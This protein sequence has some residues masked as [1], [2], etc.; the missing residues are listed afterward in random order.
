MNVSGAGGDT[1][2]VDQVNTSH[3]LHKYFFILHAIFIFSSFL[4][5]MFYFILFILYYIISSFYSK[6]NNAF[7]FILHIES[8][9]LENW[10]ELSNS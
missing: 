9:W 10:M 4:F 2:I 8:W 1:Y 3:T 7:L 6:M 5:Y